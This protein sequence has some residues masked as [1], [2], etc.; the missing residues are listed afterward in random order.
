[1]A[2]R[3]RTKADPATAQ[4]DALKSLSLIAADPV[5]ENRRA[6][7]LERLDLIYRM[8]LLRRRTAKSG[9]VIVDPDC[10]GAAH[11][12]D[13]AIPL[14]AIESVKRGQEAGLAL[15]DKPSKLEAVK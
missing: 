12:M 2:G 3:P 14:L 11:A 9:L 13:R 4:L 15:F 7:V 5:P 1:M 10:L 6:A 8:A